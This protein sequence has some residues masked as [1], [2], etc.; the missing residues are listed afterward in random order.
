MSAAS[1]I[2]DYFTPIEDAIATAFALVNVTCYT[3]LGEQI[4]NAAADAAAPD[5]K[6]E[7]QK[8]RPRVEIA[9]MPGASKGRLL[10]VAGRRVAA[11]HLPEQ[12][13]NANLIVRVITAA[14]I[15]V[16]RVYLAEVIY[17]L[18]TMAHAANATGKMPNHFLG[19]LR[20]N[21]GSLEYKASEGNF[22]S[23]LNCDL[24][25]SVKTTAWNNLT[26]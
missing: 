12:A 23:T 17:R 2:Y 18:D 14:E 10:P 11:G 15:I 6:Q 3:P 16:H 9:L 21:G 4:L 5:H 26:Q 24:D 7:F 22:E 1:D 19:G 20:N 13:R 8:K 25:F